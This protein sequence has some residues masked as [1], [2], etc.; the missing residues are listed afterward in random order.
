MF[1]HWDIVDAKINQILEINPDDP[2]ALFAKVMYGFE[3]VLPSVTEADV[4]AAMVHLEQV[5]PKTAD[6][7][8][9]ALA[10]VKM[11]WFYEFLHPLTP[12][13]ETKDVCDIGMSGEVTG[14]LF[15]TFSCE[16][17]PELY[18]P[19]NMAILTFGASGGNPLEVR[20]YDIWSVV[21]TLR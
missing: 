18:N 17:V 2:H 3:G 12:S 4:D 7:V 16:V 9:R 14:E 8:D 10:D 21:L 11:V 15:P 5:A 6:L 1:D 13:S 19:R 20:I